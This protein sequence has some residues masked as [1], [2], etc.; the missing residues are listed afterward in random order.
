MFFYVLM[1]SSKIVI[2]FVLLLQLVAEGIFCQI[3]KFRIKCAFR[4]IIMKA[5][6][7]MKAKHT[8]D[9]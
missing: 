2:G 9:P 5:H 7:A 4:N 3:F 1:E 8:A 6:I